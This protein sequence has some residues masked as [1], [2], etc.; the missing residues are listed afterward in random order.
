MLMM[1]LLNKI[2]MIKRSF[3]KLLKYYLFIIL[4]MPINSSLSQVIPTDKKEFK[5]NSKIFD[6]TVSN[7]G[8]PSLGS[9]GVKTKINDIMNLDV[10]QKMSASEIV[11]QLNYIPD[12]VSSKALQSIL[13]DLYLSTSNPP[14][15]NSDDIIKF[16]ETRLIKI[17][18]SGQ[19]KKLYQLIK[20]LPQGKRWK[21][22]R[23]WLIEYE[24]LMHQD[25]KA[26]ELINK[27]S[28]N[29]SNYFWQTSRIFCLS[30]NNKLNE[31]EFVL[32]L[33]KSK[34]FS[35]ITFENL[36]K[37]MNGDKTDFKFDKNNSQIQPIHIV[38]MDTLKI[39]IKAN[40]IADLGIEY[41]D[42]LLTLTYLTPKARSFLLDKKMNY[43]FVPSEQIV[44]NYKSFSNETLDIE[45][46]ISK[47]K[48]NPNGY[49][50]AN[51]WLSIISLND[52][53]KKVETI[54]KILKS[55]MKYDRFYYSVSLYLPILEKINSTSLT[56]KLNASI[57]KLKIVANPSLFM[58]DNLANI[59]ILKKDKEW[60]WNIILKENAWSLIPLLEEAGMLEPKSF[61]WLNIAN[62][63]KQE[64]FQETTYNKWDINYNLKSFLLTKSIQQASNS[65][66]KTL[67]LL[68]LARLVGNNPFIDF[69]VSQLLIIRQS[70]LNI[71]FV[72]LANNLTLEVM[73]SKLIT[74]Q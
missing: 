20:Q 6:I 30:I 45:K 23:R 13:I 63:F 31:S 42:P 62:E 11:K 34:G 71:G 15:G 12:I 56:K 60:D 67:T 68:L 73:T 54:F 33:I 50:R 26:C 59:L 61:N 57:K 53:I 39:P 49:S 48:A 24:L 44:E 32:D 66:K 22:W 29:N 69:D 28:R 14:R 9:I 36:F 64:M 7:L 51:V 8:T 16:L 18:S 21:I 70:L 55:E 5:T 1:F 27:E 38:M 4:I 74:F 65:D 10:W 37:I 47:Y 43:D 40:F 2:S 72:D 17:K 41:T 19:S 58:D 52:D 3:K 46:A 35:D 25:K